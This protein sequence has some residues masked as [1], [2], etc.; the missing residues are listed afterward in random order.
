MFLYIN[1]FSIKVE[2]FGFK[3]I[4]FESVT[5]KCINLTLNSML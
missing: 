1:N 3:N 4:Y 5:F 2:L